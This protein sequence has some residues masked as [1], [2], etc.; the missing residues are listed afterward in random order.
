MRAGIICCESA[1]L[2]K[3]KED[4]KMNLNAYCKFLNQNFTEWLHD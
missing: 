1:G 4:V 2:F 3:G